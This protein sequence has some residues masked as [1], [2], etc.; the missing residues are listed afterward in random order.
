MD[1]F[2]QELESLINK[3]SR[4]NISNTP[5]FILAMFLVRCLEA[6]DQAVS[7]RSEWYGRSDIS[8]RS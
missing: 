4:E 2:R 8:G 7:D 6:Y 5:D 1:E 3:H